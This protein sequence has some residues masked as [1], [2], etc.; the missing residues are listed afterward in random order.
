MVSK[1]VA[2]GW[3]EPGRKGFSATPRAF[4]LFEGTWR[5]S[6]E[7]CGVVRKGCPL[8]KLKLFDSR[9]YAVQGFGFMVLIYN[10]MLYHPLR[11][12]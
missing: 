3:R 11:V 2:V 5:S 1:P 4:N 12:G 7:P 8:K 10:G 9:H 6:L